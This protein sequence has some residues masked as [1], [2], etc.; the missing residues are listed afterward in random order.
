VVAT[1]FH[2]EKSGKDGLRLYRNFVDWARTGAPEAELVP[3]GSA[4]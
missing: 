2:P 3:A 1:Q 4:G